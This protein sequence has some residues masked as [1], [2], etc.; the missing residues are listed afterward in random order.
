LNY[1]EIP[2][3]EFMGPIQGIGK[4]WLWAALA[5]SAIGLAG[6]GGGGGGGEAP[7]GRTLS[8]TYQLV[9]DAEVGVAGSVRA[10]VSGV[11]GSPHCTLDSGAV[12]PGMVFAT[13]CS[14]Q[15]TPTQSGDFRSSLT[16]TVP[17]YAGSAKVNVSVRVAGPLLSLGATA[18]QL[19][20]HQAMQP[21]QLLVVGELSP[22]VVQAGDQVRYVIESGTLPPGIT[23]DAAGTLSGTPTDLGEFTAMVSG[24]LLRGGRP[25]TMASTTDG[26]SYTVTTIMVRL[27]VRA[28]SSTMS[29]GGST[30]IATDPIPLT[31]TPAISPLPPVDA[32]TTYAANVALPLGLRLD[33]AT[34]VVG[35]TPTAPGTYAMDI[36]ATVTLPSGQ[37]YRVPLNGLWQIEVRGIRPLYE[38]NS[39]GTRAGILTRGV[40]VTILPGAVIR[41]LPG[42]SYRYELAPDGLGNSAPTW[43]S[44]DAVTGLVSVSPPTDVPRPDAQFNF[45]LK[46]ITRRGA[47]TIITLVNWT[48]LVR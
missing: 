2:R 37:S 41:G 17:G 34:G 16:F 10:T 29:Y 26:L 19:V 23:L 9:V 31:L 44:V 30:L 32:T 40:P 20:L 12:P 6:C 18:P 14:L 43:V 33:A 15:G 38:F 47:D 24:T 1:I 28:P 7:Q 3:E 5:V 48:L 22:F 46:V 13:D 11:E 39:D 25:F 36:S 35:G 42:D 21:A 27:T 8:G 45:G 4:V